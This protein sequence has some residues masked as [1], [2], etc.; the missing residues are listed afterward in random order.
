MATLNED[1]NLDPNAPGAGQPI[2]SGSTAASIGGGSAGAGAGQSGQSKAPTSS[3]SYTNLMSYIGANQG[4]DT[5]MGNAAAAVVDNAGEQAN[6]ALSNLNHDVGYNTIHSLRSDA[7]QPG[8]PV[9]SRGP[10]VAHTP[11]TDPTQLDSYQGANDAVANVAGTE[12]S[13]TGKRSGGLLGLAGGGQS[14]VSTLLQKAYQQPNYSA[15]ENQLD[16]FLTGASAGGQS[17][18]KGINDKWGDVGAKLDAVT[19]PPPATRFPEISNV[20]NPANGAAPP[21]SNNVYAPDGYGK[22]RR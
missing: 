17:A 15:G 10:A 19:N 3:G 21:A 22:R 2:N 12:N 5:K 6:Q 14:G 8:A 18:L 20:I 9:K 11:V 7:V 16:T 1:E 4:N 13:D